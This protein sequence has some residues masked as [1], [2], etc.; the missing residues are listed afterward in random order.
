MQFPEWMKPALMGVGA[1][2]IAVSIIGFN[3]GGWVTGG[4][5]AEM[6]SD[7]SAA[8]V[9]VALTPYCIRKSRNDPG[10]VAILAELEDASSYQRH[11]VVEDAGWATPLGAEEPSR[12]LADA[13][14]SALSNDT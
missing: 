9:V 10:A 2:A 4:A 8:A 3:W 1:G 13:C 14:E 5:A 7:N 6:S 12:D 11:S